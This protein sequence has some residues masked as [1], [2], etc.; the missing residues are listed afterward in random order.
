MSIR[1]RIIKNDFYSTG[2]KATARV[3]K[4]L[5]LGLPLLHSK[6]PAISLAVCSITYPMLVR[7]YALL[8]GKRLTTMLSCKRWW[9]SSQTSSSVRAVQAGF[10]GKPAGMRSGDC[11]PDDEVS[12]KF[13]GSNLQSNLEEIVSITSNECWN[14]P[15]QCQNK[16]IPCSKPLNK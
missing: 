8:H 5:P 11:A 4:G 12:V 15:L 16:E 2:V 10:A 14:A 7:V 3:F 9:R 1:W 13:D 6:L